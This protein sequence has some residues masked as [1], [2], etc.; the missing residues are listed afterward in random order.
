MKDYLQAFLGALL[1]L[2]G[3]PLALLL[4]LALTGCESQ[5]RS[6]DMG[7]AWSREPYSESLEF[8]RWAI[9]AI[10]NHDL[11]VELQK[12]GIRR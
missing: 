8:Q 2:V 5:P 1:A 7:W 4:V 12:R 6:Q 9:R 11:A 10:D 3:L